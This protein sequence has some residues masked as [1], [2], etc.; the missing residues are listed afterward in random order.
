MF[1]NYSKKIVLLMLFV[2][3]VVLFVQCVPPPAT[4]GGATASATP[5]APKKNYDEQT[6][7]RYLSFAYSYYQNNDWKGCVKNYN[8]MLKNDCGEA[9]AEDI[10]PIMGRAYTELRAEGDQYL[11][12]AAFT[13]Q[14]GLEFLPSNTYMRKSLAY[15]Y[16]LQGKTELQIRENEKLAE[17]DPENVKYYQEL[18]K[19][20]FKAERYEDVTWAAGKILELEPSN[21]QAINDRMLAYQKLGKDVIEVQKEAWEKNPTLNTGMDYAVALEEEQ[22]YSEAIEVLKQLSATNQTNFQVYEKLGLNYKNLSDRENVIRTYTHIATKISP[23]DLN[24]IANIVE[25][26]LELFKFS[27]AYEWA[28]KAIDIDANSKVSNKLIGDV[29]Y[30]AAEYYPGNESREVSFEDKLVYK[31]AYDAYKKASAQG[32]Y[33]VK[34]R[35]DYLKEYRIPTSEDWFMNKYDS[36]GKD[37]TSFKPLLE[38]YSWIQE[39]ASK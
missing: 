12:S 6:C 21:E 11:D 18:S 9:F 15:V 16:A 3:A 14:Q 33:S 23:R 19:L 24:V 28:K 7:N 4:E 36:A 8:E 10:Y 13:Y 30:G 2:L 38:C 27:E 35:I 34:N 29:Y 17:R 1:A 32:E 5:A 31:L 25:A 39:S 37:R 20:Y 26:E 22:K